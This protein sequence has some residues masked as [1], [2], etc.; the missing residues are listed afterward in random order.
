LINKKNKLGSQQEVAVTFVAF[1]ISTAQ[2][3]DK[4]YSIEQEKFFFLI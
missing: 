3:L 1:G 4:K 2:T